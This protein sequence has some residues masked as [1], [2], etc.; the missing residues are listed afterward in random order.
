MAQAMPAIMLTQ[1]F[2]PDE[3][4]VIKLQ[5]TYD[6]D[7]VAK[8]EI[9]IIDGRTVE[10]NL[11]ALNKFFEAAEELTFD[12]GDE[13]FRAFRK[14]QKGK[15]KQDWDTVVDYEGLANM[16]GCTPAQFEICIRAWKLTFVNEESRQTLIDYCEQVKKPRAMSVE[17]FVQ[18]LKTIARY[19]EALPHNDPVHAPV[20]SPEN[21]KHIVFKA[22]PTQWQVQFVR[23][24]RGI[25]LVTLLELQN[26]M[27]NEKTFADGT[28]TGN[29]TTTNRNNLPYYNNQEAH[30]NIARPNAQF[31]HRNKRTFNR[32]HP[33][34][35]SKRKFYGKRP[36]WAND[37]NDSM[38][39]KHGGHLWS[40]CR[41]NPNGRNY[42]HTH[43][44]RYAPSREEDRLAEQRAHQANMRD[45]ARAQGLGRSFALTRPTRTLA[46]TFYR[47]G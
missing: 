16:A 37:G 8:S 27:S 19:V 34:H 35:P 46:R 36:T 33:P 12:T 14:I 30:R 29:K 44:Y 17:T 25:A 47:P 24:H 10:A 28:T 5:Q 26:F 32:G 6:D 20:L 13:L 40:N 43:N 15:I 31:Q 23:T 11:Y 18:R 45:R 1:D 3:L 41:D 42:R 4:P 9:P 38:C 22:M 21:I 39:R 2:D 7:T